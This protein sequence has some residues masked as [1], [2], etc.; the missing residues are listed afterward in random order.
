LFVRDVATDADSA[1]ITSAI[2]RLAHD[3]RLKVIAEGVET[4]EQLVY[5]REWGCDEAQGFYFGRPLPVNE[6]ARLLERG[7]PVLGAS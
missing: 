4:E 2:I 1:A 6:F 7:E 3:L 5:L